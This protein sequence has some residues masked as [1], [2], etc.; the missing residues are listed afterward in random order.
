MRRQ[1]PTGGCGAKKKLT[2]SK[3]VECDVDTE[4]KAS[5][6]QHRIIIQHIVVFWQNVDR[7]IKRCTDE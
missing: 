1:G 7:E 5:N 6:T 3:R 2:G 4:V